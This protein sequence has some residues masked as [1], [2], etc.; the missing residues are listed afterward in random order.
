[1]RDN[2]VRAMHGVVRGNDVGCMHGVGRKWRWLFMD[3]ELLTVCTS[4]DLRDIHCVH[5]ASGNDVDCMH[6]MVRRGVG[7]REGGDSTRGME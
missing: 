4:C 6:T 1:M 3:R 2:C 5:G 7:G